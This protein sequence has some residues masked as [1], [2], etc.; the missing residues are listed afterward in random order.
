VLVSGGRV[1]GERRA[2]AELMAQAMHAGFGIE[3][4]WI[5][6][7]SRNTAENAEFSARMLT[8]DGVSRVVLVTHALHMTRAVRSF[9]RHGIDVIAAPT[10][11][12]SAPDARPAWLAFLPSAG[13]LSVSSQALYELLGNAWYLATGK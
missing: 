7:G 8:V 2:E 13:A 4:R 10:H 12:Q 3:A 9:R 1:F 6:P 5:E 11:F